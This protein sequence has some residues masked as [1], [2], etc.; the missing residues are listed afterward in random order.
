MTLKN[1]RGEGGKNRKSTRREQETQDREIKV[2]RKLEMAVGRSNQL[3]RQ[4]D[5]VVTEAYNLT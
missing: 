2:G 4:R 5:V 1:M 3:Q